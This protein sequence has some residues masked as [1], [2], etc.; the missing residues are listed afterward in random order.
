M[1]CPLSWRVLPY[2]HN[3]TRQFSIGRRKRP[4]PSVV[5][6][7]D[8]PIWLF[9][10]N[11]LILSN[12]AMFIHAVIYPQVSGLGACVELKAEGNG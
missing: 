11:I 6:A 3:W 7:Q 10:S 4:E 9:L 5:S 8:S 12:L 1:D 2:E